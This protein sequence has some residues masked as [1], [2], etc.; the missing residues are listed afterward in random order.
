[1]KI[2]PNL[3]IEDEGVDEGT[4]EGTTDE[5]TTDEGAP[6]EGAPDE[7][8]PDEGTDEGTDNPSPPTYPTL[9]P[10]TPHGEIWIEFGP[11]LT[12]DNDLGISTLF[13][14]T[15]LVPLE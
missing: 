2:P 8:A 9:E 13:C 1:M 7:G 5:G 3:I 6:N 4:D 14:L 12:W 10:P 15:D 11:L